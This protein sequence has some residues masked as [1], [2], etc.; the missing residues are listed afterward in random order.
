MKKP[1][2]ASSAKK[3]VETRRSNRTKYT[4]ILNRLEFNS[5]N[6]KRT[7]WAKDPKTGRTLTP[8]EVELTR[9]EA[10]KERPVPKAKTH[11]ANKRKKRQ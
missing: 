7:G 1:Q 2:G 5:R 11:A 10:R 4:D 6:G 8:L 9:Y 3:A